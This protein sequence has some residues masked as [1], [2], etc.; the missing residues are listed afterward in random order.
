[1]LKSRAK[2]ATLANR[3]VGPAA[4]RRSTYSYDPQGKAGTD[5]WAKGTEKAGNTD[6]TR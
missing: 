3:T 1:M 5:G 6:T 2:A 4:G